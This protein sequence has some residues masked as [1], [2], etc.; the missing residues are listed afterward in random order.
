MGEKRKKYRLSVEN[1]ER[2]NWEDQ[3]I[4]DSIILKCML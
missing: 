2:D 1:L 4:D 3:N